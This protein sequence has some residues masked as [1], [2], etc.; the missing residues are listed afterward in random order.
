[1]EQL[2][3][4]FRFGL[5]KEL[6]NRLVLAPM[7]TKQ[8]FFDGAVTS[9]EI[10][11]YAQRADGVAAIIVGAANVQA[12]GKGWHGELSIENDGM[13]PGLT[14]LAT[15]IQEKGA[16]AIIQLFHAG[17]MTHKAVL[18]GKQPVSAS[19]IKA[20]REDA[21]LPQELSD[22]EILNIIKSFGKATR[23]A[24]ESGFDGIEIHGA[25]T[26]LLQQ[27][28]SPHSNRRNDR[29][30]GS[31]EKRYTF[32]D[33]VIKE[34][35]S[36]IDCMQ[37]TDFIVGYRFSPEEFEEPG[38]SFPD[39]LYLIEQ[40]KK[41]RLDYLHVSLD[42]YKRVSINN[43]YKEKS[44]LE[45][46]HQH[47]NGEKPLI[48]VGGVQ[49]REHVN[50]ILQNAEIVAVGRQLLIDPT[51]AQKILEKRDEDIILEDFSTAMDSIT[52]THPLSQFL[53]NW[54]K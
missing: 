40:L 19:S 17:R 29:W 5:G 43:K 9:D 32:I 37:A 24:I 35:Y 11:Y 33:A 10:Q 2:E 28:F 52:F 31:L 38:I 53:N 6:K 21:E 42:D 44:L 51:W 30:G 25:N 16:K 50:D 18:F 27:F 41:T 34:I 4:S 45:Y 26:Y 3:K 13:I 20:I 8:S 46:I 7:T 23:R 54:K 47:I 1:M 36:V 39:T 22:G 14:K 15:A 49:T 12:D 48:G